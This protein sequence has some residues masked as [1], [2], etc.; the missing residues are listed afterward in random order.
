MNKD[1]CTTLNNFF[2]I[3]NKKIYVM[4]LQNQDTIYV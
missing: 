4:I 3:D 2:E 1:Y